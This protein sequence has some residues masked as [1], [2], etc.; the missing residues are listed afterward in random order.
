MNSSATHTPNNSLAATTPGHRRSGALFHAQKGAGMIPTITYAR[1]LQISNQLSGTY[2]D[3][4]GAAG[5]QCWDSAAKI[6]D[7]LGLPR[8]NTWGEGRWPGWAGNMWDA[9]P[10]SPEVDAA[11]KKIPANA[12]AQAGDIALWGDGY[13]YYPKT[14]VA[15]VISDASESLICLSQNSS[16]PQPW[17]P[18]YSIYS[19]G[20]TIIQTLPKAGL[21]GYL[22]PRTTSL[23]NQG[24]TINPIQEEID[25]AALETIMKRLEEIPTWIDVRLNQI[26]E[27]VDGKFKD[28]AVRDEYN[29]NLLAGFVRDVVSQ[30]GNITSAQI[31]EKFRAML[32]TKPASDNLLYKGEEAAAVYVYDPATGFRHID[33]TEYTTLSAAGWT[34]IDLPQAV[35]NASMGVTK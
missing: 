19:T 4:D 30:Q 22:R 20:P 23:S 35:I 5:N 32:A 25:M 28:Q 16:A 12:T 2:I 15:T 7:I 24:S 29:R 13:W 3:V 6:M 27:W 26:V 33:I 18:G 17:L 21:L 1:L 9:F 10:E 34:R 11:Y 14:H 31:D 8:V